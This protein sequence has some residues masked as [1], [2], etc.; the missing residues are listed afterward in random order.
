[1]SA[2]ITATVKTWH[3]ASQTE[4]ALKVA[5]FPL[6]SDPYVLLKHARGMLPKLRPCVMS[7]ARTDKAL[8]FYVSFGADRK[9]TAWSVWFPLHDSRHHAEFIYLMIR[10][11]E[12]NYLMAGVSLDDG[13]GDG[14]ETLKVPKVAIEA[15]NE[16]TATAV[17]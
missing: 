8:F 5:R 17:H 12:L 14:G 9:G 16:L 2:S 7:L 4:R 11:K 15:F 10:G 1:M 3:P 13:D 6:S